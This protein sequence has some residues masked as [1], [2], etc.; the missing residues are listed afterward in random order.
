MEGY[1]QVVLLAAIV[2][3]DCGRDLAIAKTV[4]KIYAADR[5]SVTAQQLLAEPAA[6]RK[7]CWLQKKPAREQSVAEILVPAEADTGQ[8]EA[9]AASDVIVNHAFDRFFLGLRTHLGVRVEIPLALQV[10]A[11]I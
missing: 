1:K 11:D 6:G 10:V 4:G 8:T 3:I 5:I 7:R 2:I 9:V